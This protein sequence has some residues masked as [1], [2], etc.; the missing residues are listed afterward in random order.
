M[1][2]RL[3]KLCQSVYESLTISRSAVLNCMALLAEGVGAAVRVLRDP[4]IR[5]EKKSALDRLS[6][7]GV[8]RLVRSK[9]G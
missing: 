5:E 8:N 6:E 9:R 2:P 3:S 7:D 4:N 1:K